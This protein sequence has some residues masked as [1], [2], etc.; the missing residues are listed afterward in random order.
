MLTVYIWFC[1]FYFA[2]IFLLQQFNE[3]GKHINLKKSQTRVV[4]Y[5]TTIC[6]SKYVFFLLNVCEVRT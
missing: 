3:K 4:K 6:F 2:T 1:I 5:L